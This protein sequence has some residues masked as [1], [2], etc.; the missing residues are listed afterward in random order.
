MLRLPLLTTL[1]VEHG[2]IFEQAGVRHL[3]GWVKRATAFSRHLSTL[4]LQAD[5]SG[6]LFITGPALSFDSLVIHLAH[7]HRNTLRILDI[8]AAYLG[9]EAIRALAGLCGSLEELSVGMRADCLAS[10]LSFLA[11][12][13]N[14]ELIS[15]RR[16]SGISLLDCTLSPSLYAIASRRER[17][18]FS[19]KLL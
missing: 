3:S 2:R 4:R 11:A 16:Y 15:S 6:P 8:S 18:R 13:G 14:T 9:Q 7:R 1:V 5:V 17:C 12:C 10:L 19:T